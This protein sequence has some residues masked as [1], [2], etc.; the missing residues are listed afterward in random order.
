[1]ES[2]VNII[3]IVKGNLEELAAKKKE[4]A[5]ELARLTQEQ[6]NIEQNIVMFK[7]VLTDLESTKNNEIQSE[8]MAEK[9]KKETKKVE[10]KNTRKPSGCKIPVCAVDE[11]GETIAEY[12]SYKEAGKDLKISECTVKW[13]IDKI[14]IERQI[15]KNGYGLKL[16]V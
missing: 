4:N 13:R 15:A 16:R 10:K 8:M 12:K 5:K 3:G 11:K 1:M 9:P 14:P 2:M 7:K 6:K